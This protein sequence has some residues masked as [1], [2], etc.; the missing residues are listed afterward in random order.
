MG[1]I[2]SK[3]IWWLFA[4]GNLIVL[5]LGLGAICL[6]IGRVTERAGGWLRRLGRV[7]LTLGIGLALAITVLPLRDWVLLPLENRFAAPEPLP[8]RVDGIIV[9]GG[10]VDTGLT[11]DRG[12]PVV[13]DSADRLF[14]LLTLA[15]RYPDAKLLFTGGTAALDG[16]G[17]REA[18]VVA[19]LFQTAGIEPLLL[20]PGRLVMER[21]SRNT[22]ENVVQSKALMQ[23]Q[24][25]E[26]WLLVTSAFHMPRAVGIFRQQGWPVVPFP[27]DYGLRKGGEGVPF[28]FL[29]GL[30]GVHWGIR[31]WVGL[32]Y[33]RARGWTDTLFPGPER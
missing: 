11:D 26:V 4:P 28:S 5:A 18:D 10:A 8:A 12:Q 9:L 20:P 32:A 16:K 23:P 31:E 6:T 19:A 25:G 33:Y 3:L 29:D 15:R 22:Y 27:V 30:D 13:T 17:A 7:S 2:A 24:P 1:F 14:A 21:N